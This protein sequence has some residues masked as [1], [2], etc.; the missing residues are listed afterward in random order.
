MIRERAADAA[1]F[2][3]SSTKRSQKL[4]PSA[5]I[6][7]P[8]RIRARF[9]RDNWSSLDGRQNRYC[10]YNRN[11]IS[12]PG[13]PTIH[14][15]DPEGGGLP[16]QPGVAQSHDHPSGTLR[17]HGPEAHTAGSDNQPARPPLPNAADA[18]EGPAGP[19]GAAAPTEPRRPRLLSRSRNA[20]HS[21]GSARSR[22]GALSI[23]RIV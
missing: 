15:G 18:G 2:G 16:P 1:R 8:A 20:P 7:L 11:L 4:R 21:R 23:A 13:N 22:D 5:E 12:A 17:P 10:R 19:R 14:Y 6:E 9:D 3:L